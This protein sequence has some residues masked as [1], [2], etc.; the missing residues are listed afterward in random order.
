MSKSIVHITKTLNHFELQVDIEIPN[1]GVTVLFGPS[2]CGK[3]T[4]LNCIAGLSH[5]SGKIFVN[6]ILWQDSERILLKAYER[7][8][9]Y[10]F[11]DSILFEIMTVEQNLNYACDN[12]KGAS[13]EQL[14]SLIDQLQIGHLLD[15]NI[16]TL[17][18]GEKQRVAIVRAL[19]GAPDVL[20]FDEPTASLDFSAKKDIFKILNRLKKELNIPIIYVSHSIDEVL[21]LADHIG[22]INAGKLKEILPIEFGRDTLN[23]SLAQEADK[24]V[25]LSGVVHNFDSEFGISEVKVGEYKFYFPNSLEMN[26]E[27]LFQIKATSISLSKTENLES[28][29]LNIFPVIIENYEFVD[30]SVYVYLTSEDLALSFISKI[31]K[32]SFYKLSLDQDEKVFAQ[33]KSINLI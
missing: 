6:N 7:S 1:K 20:L 29:I 12:K 17:S 21:Q 9:G 11:Q 2:G 22:F 27:I 31:T 10:V 24:S 23:K 26:S 19:L 3:T 32:K 14:K 8:L 28:S 16:K 25:I 15:S 13:S 33:I 5:S 30:S 18:G 4:I